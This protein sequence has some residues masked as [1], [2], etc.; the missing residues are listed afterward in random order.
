[1]CI[2]K[3]KP[4]KLFLIIYLTILLNLCNFPIVAQEKF[5]IAVVD[6]D[7][8]NVPLT[9]ASVVSDFIRTNLVRIGKFRV[10]ERKRMELILAE[11][12]FQ[13]TGCTTS[14]CAVQIGK[15][16]NVEKIIV[17][18]LVKSFSL[19]YI[20]A[21][22]IDVETGEIVLSRKASREDPQLL[23]EEAEKIAWYFASGGR[24]EE[25]IELKVDMVQRFPIIK[26]V[27]EKRTGTYIKVNRGSLD[28][29]KKGEIYEIWHSPD[30]TWRK[31][32]GKI[33][34]K[35]T[36]PMESEGFVIN[37]KKNEK[38]K[39]GDCLVYEKK[40]KMWGT[41][42]KIGPVLRRKRDIGYGGFF[43]NYRSLSGIGCQMSLAQSSRTKDQ[44]LNGVRFAEELLYLCPIFIN[45][46]LKYDFISPFLGIGIS[47]Y[48]NDISPGDLSY[49]GYIPHKES[50]IA[51]PIINAGCDLFAARL[52]HIVI[53]G[54]YFR[55]AK[56][57]AGISTDYFVT[58]LGVSFN[59]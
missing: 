44:Y 56:K 37:L 3:K 7:A 2:L 42:F 54:T 4:N 48:E 39:M 8:Q 47:A 5:N 38:I 21:D 45:Y 15:I 31:F 25:Q 49:S 57:L 43:Y 9:E 46:R 1:M 51:F 34:I 52:F 26:K 19:Y 12:G 14:E 6:F 11:Q 10:V 36:K 18:K 33:I 32:V 27:R 58:T 53:E 30:K 28:G 59:W 35:T 16:L 24:K 23:E 50:G 17:G 20:M 40:R 22:M 29:L 41:G 55:G 13:Q